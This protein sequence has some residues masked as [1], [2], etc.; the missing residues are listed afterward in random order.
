MNEFFFFF[1]ILII[2]GCLMCINSLNPIHSVFWLVTVFFF[3]FTLLINLNLEF[4]SLLLIIIYVGAIVILFLF[5]IMMLDII[6]IKKN[7]NINN[8]IPI[9][10]IILSLLTIKIINKD[11]FLSYHLNNDFL[12]FNL[13]N[14]YNFHNLALFFYSKYSINFILISIILSIGMI[15]VIVLTITYNSNSKKQKIFIQHLRNNSWN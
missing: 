4:L 1:S 14:H 11:I 10:L 15:G 9:I 7:S 6:Q 3:S 2:L 12:N 5:V 8:I 13:I